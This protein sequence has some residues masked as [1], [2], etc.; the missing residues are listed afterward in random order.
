MNARVS[1]LQFFECLDHFFSEVSVSVLIRYKL[2]SEISVLEIDNK[3]QMKNLNRSF[4]TLKY[5]PLSM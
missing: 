2:K 4:V 3:R 5:L 1:Y